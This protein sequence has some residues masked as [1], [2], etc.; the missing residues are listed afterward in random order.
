MLASAVTDPLGVPDSTPLFSCLPPSVAA[1][2][3]SYTPPNAY[4]YR[5]KENRSSRLQK[6]EGLSSMKIFAT[7]SS[8]ENQKLWCT[9]KGRWRNRC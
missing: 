9:N 4:G 2:K 6:K 1:D 8:A 7:N 5:G 3:N